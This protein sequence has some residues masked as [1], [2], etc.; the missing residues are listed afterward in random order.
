MYPSLELGGASIPL[1]FV[2]I[3]AGFGLAAWVTWRRTRGLG[4]ATG[5]E[6]IDYGIMMLM[7]GVV[8]SRLAHVLVDGLLVDYIQ[9]CVDPLALKGRA[10]ASLEPCV[11]N[12]QCLRAGQE[13]EAIG[14]WCAAADGLCYPQPDC[15]RTLKFWSGG[16]TVYGALLACGGLTWWLLKRRGI[17]FWRFMDIALPSVFLGVALGRLGCFA[18][19]CCYGQV[20]QGWW[21][22]HF[23]ATSLAYA[24]HFEFHH[25]ALIEQWRSPQGPRRSLP[26]WPSQLISAGYSLG[27]F[28]AGSAWLGQRRRWDGQVALGCVAMYAVC[29]FCVEWVRADLR[30][31]ALGLSTSQWVSVALLVGVAWAWWVLSKKYQASSESIDT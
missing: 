24:D 29:R 26:V 22:V 7:L 31:Q 4:W 27:I 11:S 16:L 15:L 9:L 12:L 30:G 2:A 17:S 10:L 19:G 25:Q 8:G 23:P 13:A 1:Y 14:A 20:T 21:G 28:V 5:R 3:M 6:A 18:S